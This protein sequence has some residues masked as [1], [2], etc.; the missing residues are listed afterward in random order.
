MNAKLC[1]LTL[2]VAVFLL[3]SAACEESTTDSPE[4]IRR[5]DPG[6]IGRFRYI[7]RTAS[8]TGPR[9]SA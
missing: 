7:L 9:R 1:R 2:L 6:Y 5:E 4:P 3:G 8:I